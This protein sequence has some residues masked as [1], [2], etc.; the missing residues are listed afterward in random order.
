MFA[1]KS[2]NCQEPSVPMDAGR[3]MRSFSKVN[4]RD[5]STSQWETGYP[6]CIPL[7]LPLSTWMLSVSQQAV[8]LNVSIHRSSHELNSV[9]AKECAGVILGINK[10][11]NDDRGWILSRKVC[12]AEGAW[13]EGLGAVRQDCQRSDAME[14]QLHRT[15]SRGRG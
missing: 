3:S 1:Y 13:E 8:W 6:E 9:L 12:C 15:E 14:G 5:S 4:R 7:L 10:P 11:S 2:E